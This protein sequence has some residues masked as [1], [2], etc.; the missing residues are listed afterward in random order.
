MELK[1]IETHYNGYRFRS[2]LEARWAVFF[3][4]LKIP[5]DYEREGFKLDAGPYLPDFLLLEPRPRIWVE[6]KPEFP[7][8]EDEARALF[9]KMFELCLRS[10]Q[11]TVTFF[12]KP[13]PGEYKIMFFGYRGE[14]DEIVV[15][16]VWEN[17]SHRILFSE[18]DCGA[19]G[20]VHFDNE[21]DDLIA[22][23]RMRPPTRRCP[24]PQA[25]QMRMYED[26]A[27]MK[28]LSPELWKA[29]LKARQA[30]FEHGEH[31]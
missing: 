29:F 7:E 19:V 25:C 13:F 15:P 4:A 1:A 27:D 16:L 6:I 17:P 28:A 3:D 11:H 9:N 20:I 5:Y 22:A 14:S 8:A 30:R 2:R 18:S 10:K 26:K 31:G 21:S 12:G 24:D 23:I